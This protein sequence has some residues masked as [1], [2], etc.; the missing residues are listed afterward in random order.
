V[1][2]AYQICVQ[3]RAD[4][5]LAPDEATG[6]VMTLLRLLAFEPAG[7]GEVAA[8]GGAASKRE[9]SA[10]PVSAAV[11]SARVVAEPSPAAAMR[12]ATPILTAVPALAQRPPTSESSTVPSSE[13]R[14]S[15]VLAKTPVEWPAFVASLKLSGIVGQLAAQTQFLR[16]EG[17]DLVLG[18]PEAQRHLTDKSYVDKLKAAIDEATASKV[19]L[20]FELCSNVDV[21]LAAQDKRERAEQ[22]AQTE[23]AFRDEQF[24]RDVLARFD[25]RIKPDSIKPIS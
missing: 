8:S 14:P 12:S 9:S 25:A 7:G 3:G 20:T 18:L 23:A 19:R 2:L 21:S 22:K 4:L 1:Q 11:R 15:S 16:C 13:A 6:F 24:V 5:A 17:R 10:V